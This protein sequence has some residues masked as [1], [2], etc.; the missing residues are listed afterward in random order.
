MLSWI[1]IVV[2]QV[3]IIPILNPQVFD[4]K[5]HTIGAILKSKIKIVERGQN[6]YHQHKCMTDHF[7]GLVQAL[8]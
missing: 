1:Y 5:Y 2:T 4:Q 7:P 3:D 6:R 8:Q